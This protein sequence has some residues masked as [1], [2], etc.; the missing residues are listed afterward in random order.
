MKST[1]SDKP[2]VDMIH[3]EPLLVPEPPVQDCKHKKPIKVCQDLN[4]TL[5]IEMN[6]EIEENL[7]LKLI[8]TIPMTNQ[9]TLK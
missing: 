6:K 7:H 2:V 8:Q 9:K 1:A 5:A 4:D 3:G